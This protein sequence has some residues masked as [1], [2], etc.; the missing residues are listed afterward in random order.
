MTE[1]YVIW[2]RGINVG[3]NKRI[4]MADL[5]TLLTELG[6]TDVVTVL[7]SGNAVVTA[8]GPAAKLESSVAAG[9]KSQFG[10]EVGCLVRTGAELEAVIA[11]NS[12]EVPNGSRFY[13]LFL[14][15]APDAKLLKAHDPVALDPER[16]VLGDRVIYHW[17]PDGILEAPP[18]I[19]LVEKELK[20]RVT[21]RNWNTI[22][23]VAAKL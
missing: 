8:P 9:I 16:A 17:C 7:Q 4:A 5:R 10:M 6:Y 23:K 1:R 3:R 15:G 12:L 19:G 20:L 2:L 18:I 14:S 21:A 22:G 11:A 13:G